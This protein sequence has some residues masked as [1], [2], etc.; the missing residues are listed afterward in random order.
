MKKYS[1]FSIS[2]LIILIDQ[3]SKLIV[4]NSIEPE[5]IIRVTNKFFWLTNIQNTGASFSLFSSDSPI[6]RYLLIFISFIAIVV[7]SYL[8]MKTRVRVEK[9]VYAIILGGAAG[10]MIDRVIFG[11]VTD[12]IWV[13]FPDIIMQ[14]WPIFNLADSSIVVAII[15]MFIYTIFF[16]NQSGE[17]E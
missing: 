2:A 1:Y 5:K 10:N 16:A 7:L 6:T 12:F 3:I 17:E 15:I 8:I 14:R 11:R 9:I 13:D 4:R